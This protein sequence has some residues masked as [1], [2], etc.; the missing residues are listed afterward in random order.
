MNNLNFRSGN[1]RRMTF[2]VMI[3]AAML[4]L[5]VRFYNLQVLDE[6]IYR[7]KSEAN[8][9]KKE[10]QI[11]IRGLIYDRDGRLITDNRPAFSIYV[12]P[13]MINKNES[14]LDLLASLLDLDPVKIKRNF[15]TYP[16]L[17]FIASN[18]QNP[19]ESTPL[20]LH[21]ENSPVEMED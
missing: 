5:T 13:A 15:F 11:P 10:T 20:Q 17:R 16:V 7:Q 4:I 12:V 6:D 19:V 14:A 18:L 1:R 8:S 21:F 2:Y 9:V 3:I